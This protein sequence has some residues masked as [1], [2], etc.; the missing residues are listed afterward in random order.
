MTLRG[1][2]LLG[3]V[4]LLAVVPGCRKKKASKK[5]PATTNGPKAT[6][7]EARRI[8]PEAVVIKRI[9]HGE[10]RAF[11]QRVVSSETFGKITSAHYDENTFVEKGK[12]LA[13]IDTRLSYQKLVQAQ[14][15]LT[16]AKDHLKRTKA[17]RRKDLATEQQ[18]EEAQTR[19]K[20]AEVAVQVAR[21]QLTQNTVRAPI[22]GVVVTKHK[23]KGEIVNAGTPIVTIFDVERLKVT[24]HVPEMDLVEIA[25]G[26]DVTLEILAFPKSHPLRTRIGKVAQIGY[27]SNSENRTFPVDVLIENRD[28]RLRVGMLVRVI[29]VTQRYDNA[30]VVKRD[31]VLDK[32]NKKWVFVVNKNKAAIRQVTLGASYQGKVI[33]ANGLSEGDEL[34]VVGQ[35]DLHTDDLVRVV[36]RPA[37]AIVPAPG[38]TPPPTTPTTTN[39]KQ[40]SR[41]ELKTDHSTRKLAV[42]KAV[43][44]TPKA[45]PATTPQPKPAPVRGLT[46]NDPA[47][48]KGSDKQLGGPKDPTP[49]KQAPKADTTKPHPS[50]AP[51]KPEK[52]V[53]EPKPAPTKK[54]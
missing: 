16:A 29:V 43:T 7:V 50:T 10:T 34:V 21:L 33:V 23:D 17:L 36:N 12:L 52:T 42:K 38:S 37:P 30:V 48:P 1:I 6:N 9:F 47:T 2:V 26:K 27:V 28:R 24:F 53:N 31:V 8:K 41:D 44:P 46:S 18:L 32:D 13:R 15:N 35:M 22:S 51:T 20:N 39:Q 40:P 45:P 19:L 49:E 14:V 11:D 4:A 3:F 5:K 25:K 54:P